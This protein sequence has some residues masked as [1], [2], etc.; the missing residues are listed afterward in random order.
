[1]THGVGVPMENLTLGAWTIVRAREAQEDSVGACGLSSELLVVLRIG[2][3]VVR[4]TRVPRWFS[5]ERDVGL[6]L[7]AVAY[8]FGSEVD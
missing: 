4:G 3:R 7:D 8:A 1:M 5:M 6:L 2:R